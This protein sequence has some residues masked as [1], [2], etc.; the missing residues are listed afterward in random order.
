MRTPRRSSLPRR[1]SQSGFV[2]IALIALLA[3]GGLYFFISNLTPEAIEARRQ[4]KTD[5]ALMQARE[6]LIGYALKYRDEEAGQGRLDRMYGYLPL[7]DLGSDRNINVSCPGEGCDANTF[8]GIAFDANNIGP[9]VV[10][11]FPWRTLGT[12]PLRD[13]HGE[14]LWLIVSSLHSRIQGLNPVLPPMNWDTLGQLDIVT[15]NGTNALSSALA[16]HD[17]PVAIIFSPGPPLPGQDRS[18]PGGPDVSECGGNYNAANYLDPAVAAAL[19][20]ITNYLAGTNNASGVTGDSD[21]SNDPDDA[22]KKDLSLQG[23]VFKSG[24]NFLPGGCTG[25]GCELLANDKGL[26]ITS[27]IL[28][29][30]LRKSSSFRTDINSMLDRMSACVQDKIAAGNSI[31]AAKIASD[32]CYDD[33]KDPQGYFSHYKDQVF[34][35]S[36]A[37]SGTVDNA[38]TAGCAGTL[39]F[40]GQRQPGQRRVTVAEK[41]LASSYLES[42]NVSIFDGGGGLV[43]SGHGQFKSLASGQTAHQDIVR[44]IPAGASMVTAPSALPVGSELSQYDPVTRT[45]TLGRVNVESDQGYDASRLFGCAWTPGVRAMGSGFRGYFKFNISDPGDGFTF[46]AIDG[47]RNTVSVCGAGE[48]HLGYSGNNSYTAPIAYP[49]LG[50]E[51]DTR[52][53]YQ[54]DA[55][56]TPTGFNPARLLSDLSAFRTLANGRADPS[57]AGGHIGLVYWGGEIPISTK[58]TANACSVAADCLAPTSTC[59]AGF[60]TANLCTV[61]SDCLSP[62]FCDAGICKLNP[63]EDDNVH[64]QLPVLPATRP[65]PR[66][67]VAPVTPPTDP[68][69]LPYAVDKLD[70]SLSSVPINQDI[71]VRI[72]VARSAYAGRDDNSRLVRL[73]ASTNLAA[74]SGLAAIDSVTPVAGDTVLV[75]AQ[76]DARTNGVYIAAAGAWARAANADESADLA[77]GTSWFVKEGTAHRGSLWRL[78]NS[79]APVINGSYLVISRFREPVKAAATTNLALT[80]LQTVDGVLLAEGDRVLLAGQ[81]DARQNGVYTAS[82]GGWSR[83]AF[84]AT[85]A[86]MK[87][88]ATWSATGGAGGYWRL[89]GDAT[90]GTSNIAISA[91]SFPSNDIYSATITTQV[92]KE[93]SNANQIARMKV[94]T[95]SMNQ[96]DPVVRHAVCLVGNTCPASNPDGQSCGGVEADM[97]R[98]CYTGQK[99]KLYDSKK[100]FD[101]RTT[102][103]CGSNVSCSGNQF[104]GIDA[105][106][107]L[108]AFRT[109]RLGFTTS[110][111]TSSQ[112]VT[113]SD[114][115]STWLP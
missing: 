81:T 92:W 4:A 71:H 105:V 56:F 54:S 40:A 104:C 82:A 67:E 30:A 42:P 112:V 73:V 59:S 76:T 6:A 18:N 31:T 55:A 90:P 5:A 111:S 58:Y 43:F 3:M 47:D 13:G 38:A 113:I 8:T 52:R 63:E 74:L 89:N 109:T 57:Y 48:Q 68:A 70:P 28:F 93:S 12:G 94:T 87:D 22:Q 27:D 110:Q 114:F 69:Y 10:G 7:P 44:C 80:G 62:S 75:T 15:A 102:T 78:Q 23:A 106:C 115:F 32:G 49:K 91:L 51:F 37:F 41:A 35:A 101:V 16:V 46:A 29:G 11:R 88:G 77:P 96:L 21:I 17:R 14:C 98:Y 19:A 97:L 108:P 64:G 1:A 85:T 24:A 95:R 25:A 36:G 33:S 72:E 9:T 61:N 103:S 26:P 2:L 66:N 100:V 53:N 99:P 84:E 65:P 34:V 20:G 107:Y 39:V 45:V 60:C 83:A 50:L 79:E 86:G